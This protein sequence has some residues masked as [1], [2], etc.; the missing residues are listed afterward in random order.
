[1]E[2][3][4]IPAHIFKEVR[5]KDLDVNG[6]AKKREQ[7]ALEQGKYE[8]LHNRTLTAMWLQEL[9]EL[10]EEVLKDPAN[11]RQIPGSIVQAIQSTAQIQIQDSESSEEEDSETVTFNLNS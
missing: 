9:Q 11:S 2:K 5:L 8:Y 6:A 4:G 7:L 10:K 3:L 1:M